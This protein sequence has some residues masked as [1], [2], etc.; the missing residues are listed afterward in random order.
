MVAQVQDH[1]I[2]SSFAPLAHRKGRKPDKRMKPEQG[3]GGLGRNLRQTIMSS[4]MGQLVR[5]QEL[6]LL[7]R[8]PPGPLWKKDRRVE[9]SPG[10]WNPDFSAGTQFNGPRDAKAPERDR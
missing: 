8:P 1:V 6:E 9:N 7:S 5:Q 3:T 4:D 10:E 2:T